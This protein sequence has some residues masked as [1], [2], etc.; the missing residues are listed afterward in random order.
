MQAKKERRR[1]QKVI[2][3]NI[4]DGKSYLFDV[5]KPIIQAVSFTAIVDSVSDM[6]PKGEEYGDGSGLGSNE[7]DHPVL[8][9]ILDNEY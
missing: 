7:L 5:V 1:G 4:H 8:L 3:G 6:S 9:S 2:P